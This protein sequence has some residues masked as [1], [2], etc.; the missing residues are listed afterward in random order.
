MIQGSEGSTTAG[1][2]HGSSDDTIELELTGEQSRA[3]AH[4]AA[5]APAP[6]RSDESEPALSVRETDPFTYKR[7]ARIDF[8]SNVTF[9]V[10]VLA[11]A[12]AVMWPAPAPPR[13]SPPVV[14]RAAPAAETVPTA[15]AVP[16]GSPV[17]VQ[18]AF[19]ATE[20]FE[21]PPGTTESAAREAVA[22]LLLSR[23]RDRLARRRSG[24]LQADRASVQ[25]QPEVFV[26][27][28]LARAKEP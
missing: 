10:A 1:S 22:E 23:A 8:A 19:D 17:R 2:A 26:T 3:L 9:A 15:P 21:F 14:A 16:Q 18:N 27:R 7:T 13:P 4:V 5:G 28:L 6:V 25:Q 20:V 12:V 24:D 11:V